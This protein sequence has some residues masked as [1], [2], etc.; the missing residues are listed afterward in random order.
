[1][2]I[3]D[4]EPGEQNPENKNQ[5]D[6]NKQKEPTFLEKIVQA[7]GEQWRDPEIL[8]KGKHEADQHIANLEQQLAEMR[9]DLSK[10]DYAS[11]LLKAL[12][13]SKE[14]APN[15]GNLESKPNGNQGAA[16][17]TDTTT[18]GEEQIKDL[19][20]KT[21][22]EQEAERIKA[23]HVAEVDRVMNERHGNDAAKVLAEAASKIGMTVGSLQKIAEDS[24]TAFFRLI[25]EDVK[26]TKPKPPIG[27]SSVNTGAVNQNHA[28]QRNWQ[29]YQELRRKNRAEYYKPATQRQLM[30]DETAMGE[31]F[32]RPA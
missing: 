13:E 15:A 22:Q 4:N 11:E 6:P 30:A 26:E 12:K 24:P 2:S 31:A 20:G 25:G 18:F 32:G 28:G 7:K 9:E 10:Q 16:N 21:I 3:F 17:G 29:Y 23:Q 5:D 14:P 27:Q 1:M 19:V 8:A